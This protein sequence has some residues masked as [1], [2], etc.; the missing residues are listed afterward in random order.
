MIGAGCDIVRVREPGTPRYPSRKGV[1]VV[2]LEKPLEAMDDEVLAAR[3][4]EIMESARLKGNLAEFDWDANKL[5]AARTSGL[6]AKR[7]HVI[8]RCVEEMLLSCDGV[9]RPGDLKRAKNN[10]RGYARR[11][12]L[13]PKE[14]RV[15][16]FCEKELDT[17]RKCRFFADAL[18][19]TTETSDPAGTANDT[20][21]LPVEPARQHHLR[22]RRC[23]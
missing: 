4:A 23:G 13:T 5:E 21:D 1:Q 17:G 6:S 18:A 14:L 3:V 11:R 10:A 7:A 22:R 20:A 2:L 8:G 15:L 16:A 12:K 19:A 9:G